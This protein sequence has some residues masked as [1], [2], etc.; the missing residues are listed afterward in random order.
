MIDFIICLFAGFIVGYWMHLLRDTIEK[1]VESF[2]ED[3]YNM[4]YWYN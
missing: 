1:E 4:D 3:G 2:K